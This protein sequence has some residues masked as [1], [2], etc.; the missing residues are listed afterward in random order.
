MSR[1]PHAAAL[2]GNP[3]ARVS[4][5]SG[6]PVATRADGKPAWLPRHHSPERNA[7]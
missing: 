3:P 2:I 6:R 1:A 4:R 7:K 5:F